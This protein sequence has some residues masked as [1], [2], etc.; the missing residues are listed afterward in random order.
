MRYF[1]LEIM[2]HSINKKSNDGIQHIFKKN[3]SNVRNMC[4]VVSQRELRRTW[5]NI[6][7]DLKK[8]YEE[9]I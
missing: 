5:I 2:Y 6:N 8:K 7:A 3:T 9:D 1:T 4:D